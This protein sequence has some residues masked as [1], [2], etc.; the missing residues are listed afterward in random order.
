MCTCQSSLQLVQGQRVTLHTMCVVGTGPTG[1]TTGRIGSTL[2][3]LRKF[4]GVITQT[5]SR[6]GTYKHY[7]MEP[8]VNRHYQELHY[9][10]SSWEPLL[11]ISAFILRVQV[12]NRT[13]HVCGHFDDRGMYICH[14]SVDSYS[15]H[16]VLSVTYPSSLH[17]RGLLAVVGRWGTW[18][19]EK[20]ERQH[21][22]GATRARNSFQSLNEQSNSR[23]W[24]KSVYPD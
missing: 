7:I 8:Q 1:P 3:A 12:R 9:L 6:S 14:T 13:W 21:Q 10:I 23:H 5:Y 20:G 16:C 4:Y 2:V 11:Q 17:R 22:N 15:L 24:N 18:R 19:K